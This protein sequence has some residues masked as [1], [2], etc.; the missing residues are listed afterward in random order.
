MIDEGNVADLHLFKNIIK[1]T[2]SKI[3]DFKQRRLSTFL[4]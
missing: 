4:S 3:R 1:V 2:N